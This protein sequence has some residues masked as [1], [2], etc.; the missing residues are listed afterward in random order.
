MTDPALLKPNLQRLESDFH[1]L[2]TFTDS[3]FTGHT[4]QVLSEP[5]MS[6]REWIRDTMK[7]AG[8]EVHYDAAGNTIGLL[9]G[10]G[11]GPALATGSHTDTV[12]S[13]GRFDGVIGVLGAIELVRRLRETSTVLERDLYVIDFLGEEPNEF[14][15]SCVGSRSLTGAVTS[16]FFNTVNAAGTTLGSQ[17]ETVGLSPSA[18]L[19]N[20]WAHGSLHAFVELHIEQGPVLERNSQQLGVVTAI[21]GI[22]RVVAT[23]LGRADHAGT[24][25]MADRRDALAAAA[26]AVLVVEQI[27]CTG[28]HSV[29]TVGS[30]EVEPGAMNVVPS[31]ARIWTEMRSPSAEWLGTAR[32]NVLDQLTAL[33]E[34]RDIGVD[35]G[36][37]NDQNPVPTATSV[38][39]V[40][41]NVSDELGYSW[42]AMPS[43]AGHDAA[44][45]ALLAPT[46]MIFVPS[47]DGRSHC[48]EEW[49]DFDD[50]GV[51]V[52]ALGA[53]LLSLDG[54]RS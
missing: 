28:E 51:G 53:S 26:E 33:A 41:A 8:L 31:S 39:D 49:T 1:E 17:L 35:L 34:R 4:R 7:Q 2:S 30:I 52:H 54:S 3:S 43:G 25:S 18:M 42:R 20:G 9:K 14:G 24:T 50:V 45:L 12:M 22:E 47:V 5:Y 21:A 6:S 37:L 15:V 13:G 23:F 16:D 44:H 27:G 48:P 36:W 19:S 11:N 40:I 10:S 29:A 38:Q 46:G 32:R